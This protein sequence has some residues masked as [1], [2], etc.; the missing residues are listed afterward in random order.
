MKTPPAHALNAL[1]CAELEWTEAGTPR[2]VDGDVYYSDEDGLAESRA[3]FLAG[4]RLPERFHTHPD[5]VLY[6]A[7]TGFGTGL[8]FLALWQ[9]WRK[10]AAPKP[11]LHFLSVERTPLK[12]ADLHKALS[13]WPELSEYRDALLQHYPLPLP[14]PHRLIFES[15]AL[16]LDLYL[17][18]VKDWLPWLADQQSCSVDAWFLDGFAP[19]VN[20]ELWQTQLFSSMATHSRAH[21]TLATFT[22]AGFV[23]RGLREAGFEVTKV[24][25]FGRKRHRLDA[26]ISEPVTAPPPAQTPWHKAA[27]PRIAKPGAHCIVLGAGLAGSSA[28]LALARRGLKVSV[29]DS[30]PVAGAASGNRQGVL[31]TRLSAQ[32]SPV[33]DYALTSYL[34]ALRHYQNMLASGVLR[35]GE[36]G[37]LCGALHLLDTPIPDALNTALQALPAL[38]SAGSAA[39]EAAGVSTDGFS[40][41]EAAIYYPAAGWLHP[42]AVCRAQLQHP[43]ITV[44]AELGALRLSGDAE[45]WR[46]NWSCGSL[47]A[48]FVVVAMGPASVD[49]TPCSW[50]PL[51]AIRGQ[52]T[53]LPALPEMAELH[54]V[55]CHEGYLPPAHQG[56]HCIGASYVL[57]DNDASLRDEEHRSNLD[58]LARAMPKLANVLAELDAS[59]LSGRVSFRSSSPDYLPIVGSVPE[60]EA[61]LECYRG[62]RANARRIIPES[63]PCWPGLY[64]STAHGS[65]GLTSTPLAAE[66]LA[67]EICGEPQPLSDALRRALAPGRFLI[68]DLARNRL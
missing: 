7:E 3:V 19:A 53:E 20:P 37:A 22:A 5:A 21:A 17:G 36:D 1:P 57:N 45:A 2:W 62:L 55:L 51:R 35:D 40:D 29:L 44:R 66:V 25:G 54:S 49:F 6:V 64:V 63:A 61:F 47:S 67:A 56:S 48:P 32:P 34:F 50:L 59:A 65:R 14:G 28:A 8:N 60:R 13:R 33:M 42:P 10:S 24:P 27:G 15:G 41:S 30:G 43:G 26:R 68:R 39:L 38:A 11:R 58:A 46:V 16:V 4:N 23:A 52:V 9:A 18:D 31:Y 12:P